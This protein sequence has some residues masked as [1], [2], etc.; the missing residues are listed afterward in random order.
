MNGSAQKLRLAFF[1]SDLFSLASLSRLLA[2]KSRN[3]RISGIDVFTRSIKPTGRK[4]KT[5]ID[6][7]VGEFG[8]KNGLDVYRVDSAQQINEFCEKRYDLAVAVSFGKLI[9]ASFLQSLRFGGLNVHPSFLPK[10][11]G[12]SPIQHALMNDCRNTGVTVQTLHPTKFDHGA[13]LRQSDP[14]AIGER[15]TFISL[16]DR[17]A[18]VG[19][20][21]LE[22]V[23]SNKD[24]ANPTIL[25]SSEK[26][27]LAPK[28]SPTLAEIHWNTMTSRQICRLEDAL[29]PL[30][31][32][33]A[34][35]VIKKK[36]HR[37]E[38][39]KVIFEGFNEES[40]SEM[41]ELTKPGD[42]ILNGNKVI[43]KTADSY[44][45]IKKLKYQF[46]NYEAPL[47]FMANLKLRA[48]ETPLT[49]GHKQDEI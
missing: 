7:P 16:R 32:F 43:V 14:I 12:S 48:G 13:I 20:D 38:P 26:Y 3:K 33:K 37:T 11:S 39:A 47:A 29:G 15:E 18:V 27:S 23:I 6:V 19:A 9:P 24:L 5:Y 49:F 41:E 4:L 1:G 25:T 10:Y 8:T 30:F 17:L 45:S 28:I 46:C 44:V 35:D 2:M 40:V 36:I 42:F 21:L 22:D 31:S 34:V